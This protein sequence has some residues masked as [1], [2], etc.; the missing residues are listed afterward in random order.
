VYNAFRVCGSGAISVFYGDAYGVFD[1]CRDFYAFAESD[2]HHPSLPFPRD[3]LSHFAIPQ[4][5]LLY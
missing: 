4:F 1:V 5:D 2:E 3:P